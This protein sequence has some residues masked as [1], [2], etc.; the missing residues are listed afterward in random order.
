MDPI[1]IAKLLPMVIEGVKAGVD[2]IDRLSKDDPDAAEQA[3]DWLGVT[4][5]VQAAIDTW[6]ASKKT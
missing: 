4:G 2:I 5:D 3:T 6:E 1:L